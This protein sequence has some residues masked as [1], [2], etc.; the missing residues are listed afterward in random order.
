MRSLTVG[1]LVLSR[2]VGK[3]PAFVGEIVDILDP[4]M[5]PRQYIIRAENGSEWLRQ[6]NE[7]QP[8]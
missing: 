5:V 2:P 1:S 4:G 8:A 7:I 3:L 6:S